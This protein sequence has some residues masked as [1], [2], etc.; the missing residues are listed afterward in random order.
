MALY[1]SEQL[2]TLKAAYANG[3]MRVR[4]GETWVEYQSMAAIRT[5]IADIERE[6]NINSKPQGT[7]V[8]RIN[9]GYN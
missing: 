8:A 1:T 2:A 3:I 6:L 7:R 4:E 9:L 5:A